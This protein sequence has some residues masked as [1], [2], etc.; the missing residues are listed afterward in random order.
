MEQPVKLDHSQSA[1]SPSRCRTYHR[2]ETGDEPDGPTSRRRVNMRLQTQRLD[3]MLLR[4][5]SAR[6]NLRCA[7]SAQWTYGAG[8]WNGDLDVLGTTRDHGVGEV[9]DLDA[10]GD[11]VVG[12][13]YDLVGML[14]YWK[15]NASWEKGMDLPR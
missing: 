15:E 6:A 2:T 1:G 3:T 11:V 4:C 12:G 14:V 13:R 7:N 8:G 10:L 5:R 9:G